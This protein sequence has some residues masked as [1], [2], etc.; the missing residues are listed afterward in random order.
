METQLSADLKMSFFTVRPHEKIALL[1]HLLRDVISPMQQTVIFVATRHHVDF[2]S[3]ILERAQI[4]SCVVYGAMDL[5]ARKISISK[6]RNRK[7][8]VLIVTDVAARGIGTHSQYDT[9]EI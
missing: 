3:L 1:L 7:T 4:D 9:R 8:R 5:D 2:L 6:F